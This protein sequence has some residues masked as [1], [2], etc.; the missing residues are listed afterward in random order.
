MQ[1]ELRLF[2]DI[3]SSLIQK[4]LEEPVT[5]LIESTKMQDY[6]D[7]TLIDAPITDFDYEQALR[8]L[9]LQTPR[10]CSTMFFNQLFGGREPKAVLGDLLAVMLNSSMYTYK[11]AG[12][13]VGVEQEIIRK[14]CHM[15]GFPGDAGG[16]IAPGGSISNLMAMIMARDALDKNIRENGNPAGLVLYTSVQSH[17]SIPKNAAFIGL[18]KNSVRLIECDDAGKMIPESLEKAILED[19]RS[20]LVPFFVNV[21]AGTTVF[22]VF[23]P[24]E[25]IYRICEKHKIWMHVDGAYGGSVIFSKK[26]SQLLHGLEKAD[27]FS[28]NAHKML[29]T[30]LT[31]SLILVRNK[32][33]L[34]H[35]FGDEASYLFQT[36]SDD[37]N[38]G[39][40]SMQCGRRNDALKLWTLWKYEGTVGLQN[41]VDK[42]ISLAQFARDYI[43]S[44]PGYVIYNVPESLTVCFNYRDYPASKLCQELY[45]NELAMIGYGVHHGE[46]F[47]RLVTVNSGL[48]EESILNFFRIVEAHVQKQTNLSLS[49]SQ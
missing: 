36:E 9:I 39:K 28:I 35:S 12:L 3:A 34:L 49:V 14:L 46:E 2:Q 6:A 4:E 33:H 19:R 23:D 7:L 25:P 21:T 15:A 48:S 1:T 37:Y 13:Q 5:P 22:G 20:K 29:G 27:S 10:T 47:L 40:I 43:V 42:Q 16:T 38:P 45:E 26:H 32:K 17:Y 8:N 44:T 18:G 30:P 24:I 31:C 11:V 41:R